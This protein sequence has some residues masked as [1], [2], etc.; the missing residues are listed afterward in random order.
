MDTALSEM[1]KCLPFERTLVLI[2]PDGLQRGLIGQVLS[3]F[4]RKGLKIIGL[5]MMQIDDGILAEH[6]TH[7]KEKPFFKS[8]SNFMKSSPV[9][10][11]VLEGLET[12]EA[13]RLIAGN[14]KSRAAEAGSIRGDFGMGYT[15]NIIHA[16]D[17]VESAKD[18]IK[19]FFKPDELFEYD[20]TEYMNIYFCEM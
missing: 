20:K 16:S 6:Y 5:K 8:L 10:A 2:K 9:V 15:S 19:R 13:V 17:S 1:K 7:H 3:R 18:E 14:T 11:I 12:V 4:E